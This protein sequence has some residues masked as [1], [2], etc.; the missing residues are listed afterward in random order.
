[1]IVEVNIR[2][3]TFVVLLPSD[4]RLDRLEKLSSGTLSLFVVDRLV[5]R[6]GQERT[7]DFRLDSPNEVLNARFTRMIAT[8][9]QRPE[10]V[11]HRPRWFG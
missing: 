9:E 10:F 6:F 1:M 7:F 5:Q 4:T 8:D 2:S 3:L 11:H